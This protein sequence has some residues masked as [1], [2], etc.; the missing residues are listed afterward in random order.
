MRVRPYG[1]PCSQEEAQQALQVHQEAVF[2]HRLEGQLGCNKT[3]VGR[4]ASAPRGEQR[5]QSH[6]GR[7]E[8][9][10]AP[11]VLGMGICILGALENHGG[12]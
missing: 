7:R 4:E 9:S 11:G 5:D 12:V 6:R 8:R 3:R 2:E 10:P 1:T